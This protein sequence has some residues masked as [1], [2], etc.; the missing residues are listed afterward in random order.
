MLR[1]LRRHHLNDY[2]RC[3]VNR[4]LATPSDTGEGTEGLGGEGPGG[5]GGGDCG[6][7]TGELGVRTA[8]VTSTQQA[9]ARLSPQLQE[10]FQRSLKLPEDSTGNSKVSLLAFSSVK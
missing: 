5:G 3:H 9:A 4:P 8:A 7:G 6:E 10:L 2:L 1:G